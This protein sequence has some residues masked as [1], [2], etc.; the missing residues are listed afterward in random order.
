M[1]YT[2]CVWYILLFC[3][4]YLLENVIARVSYLFLL[5]IM[6]KIISG[7]KIQ[8]VKYSNWKLHRVW[9]FAWILP[10][11]FHSL[12]VMYFLITEFNRFSTNTE[13]RKSP[14]IVQ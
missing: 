10:N 1:Y 8:N 13:K 3:C 4:N 7:T 9:K 2:I 6:W 5:F 12:R 14:Y 11:C